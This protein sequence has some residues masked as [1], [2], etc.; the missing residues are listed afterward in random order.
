MI[1]SRHGRQRTLWCPIGMMKFHRLS[2]GPSWSPSILHPRSIFLCVLAGVLL[3]LVFPKLFTVFL[4]LV[5]ING[6]FSFWTAA[7]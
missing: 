6:W 7:S 1:C 3:C 2:I 5:S 4:E